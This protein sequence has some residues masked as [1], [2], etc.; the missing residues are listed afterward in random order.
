VGDDAVG[1]MKE[2]TKKERT[3]SGSGKRKSKDKD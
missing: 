3:K 2:S 1:E